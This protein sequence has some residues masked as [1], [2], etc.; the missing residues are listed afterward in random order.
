MSITTTNKRDVP[1]QH[2]RPSLWLRLFIGFF[3]VVF[4]LGGLYSGYLFYATVRA[5][6]AQTD[7]PS[8][9]VVQFPSFRPADVAAEAEMEVEPIPELPEMTPV[10]SALN[11]SYTPPQR[12]STEMSEERINV[13]LLGI[14]RRSSKGWGYRTD[15]IIIVTVDPLSKSVGMMSIPRDLYLNI[16]GYGE[17]RINVANVWGYTYNYPGGGPALLK[18][19]IEHNFGIPI[20]YYVMVDFDGFKQLVDTLG[21]IDVNVPRALHDTMY[22]DPRPGDPYAYKT[23]HFDAG[24]QHMNGQRALTY[25]RSRMSTSDFDRADRQQLI[26]IAIRERALSLNIIPKLPSLIATMGHMVLTDMTLNEM[27]ELAMLA[28]DIDMENL[29]QIVL[30]HPYVKSHKTETGAS[31][32]LPRWDLIDPA[33]SDLFSAPVHVEPT[34]TP[35][36]PTPT[37]TLAPIQIEGLEQLAEEGARIAVQNGTSEPNFAARIAAMLLEQGFQVVE[38]GDADRLDYPST[39]IV[40]YTDKAYTLERLIE[41]FQVTPENVRRSSNLTSQFDIRIIVGRDTLL[42]MPVE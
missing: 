14:D 22:P 34:S 6:V 19:T 5:I 40:D 38:F 8:L 29:K 9:P 23:V 24:W 42:S 21:G 36:P 11:L 37:P 30:D 13:L 26:L 32:Q 3:L 17:Q 2:S 41:L 12:A 1:R 27:V 10:A 7:L 33:V 18:R 39:V 35:A 15:T 28:P 4:I 25:A 16:P 20:D 31:V